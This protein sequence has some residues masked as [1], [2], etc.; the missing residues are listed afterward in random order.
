MTILR[1][2]SDEASKVVICFGTLALPARGRD[3]AVYFNLP[4]SSTSSRI[5]DFAP[6]GSISLVS[7]GYRPAAKSWSIFLYMLRGGNPMPVR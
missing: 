7:S 4:R 6:F 5:R 2:C 3:R 1:R